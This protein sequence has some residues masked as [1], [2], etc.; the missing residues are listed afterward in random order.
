MVKLALQLQKVKQDRCRVAVPYL[1][2]LPRRLLD[3]L[4]LQ[5]V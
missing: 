3:A 2:A 1:L 5:E 4:R